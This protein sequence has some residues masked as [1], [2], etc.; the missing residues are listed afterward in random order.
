MH[1]DAM[2]HP[3]YN[4][5]CEGQC[6]AARLEDLDVCCEGG[7]GGMVL[8][9]FGDAE[10]RWPKGLRGFLY[11]TGMLWCFLG[12]AIIADLFMGAAASH[13]SAAGVSLQK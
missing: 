5:T 13:L 6:C 11:L 8:P 1:I 2:A 4:D 9:M 12:V 10:Q 7:D 3:S